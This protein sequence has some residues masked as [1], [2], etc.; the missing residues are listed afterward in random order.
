[1]GKKKE[2]YTSYGSALVSLLRSDTCETLRLAGTVTSRRR[3]SKRAHS[4]YDETNKTQ[5]VRTLWTITICAPNFLIGR[6]TRRSSG[7]IRRFAYRPRDCCGQQFSQSSLGP[8]NRVSA[9]LFEA[10][11][12]TCLLRVKGKQ[13][14]D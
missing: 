6:P 7:G 11:T 4:I 8:S 14:R 12:T 1:M 3:P 13:L 10:T 9:S 2:N 5:L